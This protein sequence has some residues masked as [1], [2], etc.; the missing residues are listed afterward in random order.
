MTSER[1]ERHCKYSTPTWICEQTIKVCL[2]H[3][4]RNASLIIVDHYFKYIERTV[5]IL[6]VK[7]NITSMTTLIHNKLQE[8][9]TCIFHKLQDLNYE[10][11]KLLVRYEPI[12]IPSSSCHLI[13][14]T[15]IYIDYQCVVLLSL[16]YSSVGNYFTII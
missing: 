9:V 16:V 10:L 13:I 3:S 11:H 6:I 14:G 5:T 1:Y 4:Y 15:S 7:S 8:L 12:P 2:W